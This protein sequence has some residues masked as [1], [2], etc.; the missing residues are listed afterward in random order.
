MCVNPFFLP[1]NVSNEVNGSGFEYAQRMNEVLHWH[2]R[3]G[4]VKLYDVTCILM[5]DDVVK[6][7][8]YES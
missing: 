4:H 1:D 7:E 5:F 8:Y 6:F 2:Y 3:L